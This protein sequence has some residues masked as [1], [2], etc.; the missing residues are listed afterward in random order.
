MIP[1][2]LSFIPGLQQPAS[3]CSESLIFCFHQQH[4]ALLTET[5]PYAMPTWADVQPWGITEEEL[6]FFGEWE[7]KACYATASIEEEPPTQLAHWNRLRLLYDQPELFWIAGRGHHLAHWH[8]THRFCGRCGTLTH[9]HAK[10]HARQCPGCTHVSYPRISPAVIMAVTKGDKI[11][12]GKINRPGINLFSVLA[13]FVEPGESLEGCVAREVMEETGI[14]VENVR[15]FGSQ[16]WPFPDQMMV[17]F[18]A[19]YE[20]GEIVLDDELE[21]AGW[22]TKEELP[23]I[24]PKPSIARALID[25]FVENH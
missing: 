17:G 19:E 6:V 3:P 12:L 14:S 23:N 18:T 5:P 8:I 1:P 7:G 25:W 24:P 15:Y 21:E 9:P 13:G 2:S 10:E 4:L 20:S 16:P 11:L 22:F